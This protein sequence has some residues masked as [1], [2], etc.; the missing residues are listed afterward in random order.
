MLVTIAGLLVTQVYWFRKSFAIEESQFDDKMNIALRQVAHK[1]LLERGDSTSQIPAVSK[2]SSNE[3]F[4]Q[5]SCYFNLRTLDSLL[6]LEMYNRDLELD[7][8]Y[9]IL[10]KADDQVILGNRNYNKMVS[11]FKVDSNIACASREELLEKRNF[12]IRINN[13]R[14]HLIGVMGIWVYSSITLLV[15]LAVFT[16]IIVS[17]VKGKKLTMLKK[18]FV[19]NMTHEL[20]T[21]I[22]NI[23][24]ASDAIRNGKV[25]DPNKLQKYAEIIHKE[26]DRLHRL[27]DRVLQISEIEKDQESLKLEELDAHELIKE[28]VKSFATM[29]NSVDGNVQLELNAVNYV[30]VAD[31]M[32]L[33]N[34]I[35]N[36]VENAIKYS[37]SSPEI[38]ICTASE[39]KNLVI[40]VKDKGVGI[41]K[42]FHDR[43]FEKFYRV[44][45]GDIH[46]VP[47]YGLG[48]SYVKLIAEKHGGSVSY[49]RNK[50]QGSK[51]SIKIP[52]G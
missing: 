50:D 13:K 9:M 26:N 15:I 27:V 22:A 36:L 3:Y 12:K 11:S 44:E 42:Q 51:F 47:G 35:S 38:L 37:P 43:I 16:F 17:I 48:L 6:T 19:N 21:P 34:A 14:G 41:D 45:S 1:I 29:I 31:R 2:L 18:D 39:G 40:Q 28:V 5:P 52:I 7:Y 33:R 46:N 10:K 49:Q 4:V 24:V 30:V 8:D 32:H 23:S 20:K 25:Q